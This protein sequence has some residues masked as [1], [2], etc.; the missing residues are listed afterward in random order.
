MIDG[1]P[2][3]TLGGVGLPFGAFGVAGFGRR[4]SL[5]DLGGSNGE[6]WGADGCGGGR[7]HSHLKYKKKIVNQLNSAALVCSTDG[8][9]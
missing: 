9:A 4:H 1:A 7:G 6:L 2:S 3:W 5:S 8:L